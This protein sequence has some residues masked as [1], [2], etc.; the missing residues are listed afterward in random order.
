M[1]TTIFLF[2]IITVFLGVSCKDKDLKCNTDT[3]WPVLAEASSEDLEFVGVGGYIN[4]EGK[5]TLAEGGIISVHDTISL[6]FGQYGGS[7]CL[8]EK[9]ISISGFPKTIGDTI[10]LVS[11]LSGFEDET[12]SATYSLVDYDEIVAI[13]DLLPPEVYTSWM[14]IERIGEC[15]EIYGQFELGFMVAEGFSRRN[16]EMYNLPEIIKLT[17]GE[18]KARRLE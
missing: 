18:F 16:V 2:L 5:D 8:L 11:H 3:S 10:Y 14:V 4:K 1:K 7:N 15:G 6:L 13:Y 9:Q 12:I 17:N